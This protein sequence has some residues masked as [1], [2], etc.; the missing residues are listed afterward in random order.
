M[1]EGLDDHHSLIPKIKT[2]PY[3]CNMEGQG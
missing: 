1:V 2:A 3:P